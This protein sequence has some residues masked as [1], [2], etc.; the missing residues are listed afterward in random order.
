VKEIETLIVEVTALNGHMLF[1]F[2]VCES[3][4]PFVWDAVDELSTLKVLVPFLLFLSKVD[5]KNF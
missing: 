2:G 1:I 4:C 3:I 5:L